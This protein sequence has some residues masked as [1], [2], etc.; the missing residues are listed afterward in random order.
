MMKKKSFLVT[1]I[2]SFWF[3]YTGLTIFSYLYEIQKYYQDYIAQ[4]KHQVDFQISN[5]NHFLINQ[6][7]KSLVEVLNQAREL[8][9]FDFYILKE[10]LPQGQSEVLGY[11]TPSGKLE[12][13]NFNYNPDNYEIFVEDEKHCFKTVSLFNY[14]LTIGFNKT[15]SS[16]I[17]Q[18]M[19]LSRNSIIFDLVVVT[20]LVFL[21]VYFIMKD[22]LQI[23]KLLGSKDRHQIK[24]LHSF[25]KEAETLIRAAQGFE[26]LNDSLKSDNLLLASSLGPAIQAELKSG[27]TPP[28]RLQCTLA[29]VDLNG[30]TQLFL[31]KSPEDL[32]GLLSDYF[33]QSRDLIERYHGSVYQYVGDEIVFLFK[34]RP[35]QGPSS[36]RALSTI[37]SL[38]EMAENLKSPGLPQG[39]RLKASLVTSHRWN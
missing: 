3:L 25:S 37:R 8:H 1:I 23:S 15:E 36:T 38:F 27:K 33:R 5:A 17:S 34:E 35:G 7:T 30:Y 14:Q 4:K 32:L 10:L 9:A 19:T 6:K 12:D 28:Y 20:S 2:V 13:I 29:R 21:I 22:I 26:E 31:Q 39:V 24:N 11:Y 18:Q 16:F